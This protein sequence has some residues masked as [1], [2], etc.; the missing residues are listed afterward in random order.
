MRSVNSIWY[1]KIFSNKTLDFRYV[2]LVPDMNKNV[3]S[4]GFEI[5]LSGQYRENF[6]SRVILSKHLWKSI[7]TK[8]DFLFSFE[9]YV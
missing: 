5:I 3:V 2:A 7:K 4:L 1:L 6:K 9:V 8:E